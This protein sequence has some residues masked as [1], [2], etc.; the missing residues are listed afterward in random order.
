M[1]KSILPSLGI[2]L[3][4][5]ASTALAKESGNDNETAGLT[6]GVSVPITFMETSIAHTTKDNNGDNDL[7]T[8]VVVGGSE[9]PTITSRTDLP[10]FSTTPITTSKEEDK[11]EGGETTAPPATLSPS[12]RGNTELSTPSASS[13]SSSPPPS[14]SSS[15]PVSTSAE[16]ATSPSSSSISISSSI[17]SSTPSSSSSSTTTIEKEEEEQTNLA[18]I[19]TT[20]TPVPSVISE[21]EP[22]STGPSTCAIGQPVVKDGYT[23]YYSPV[24]SGLSSPA[25]TTSDSE[26]GAARNAASGFIALFLSLS[27]LLGYV[28]AVGP[29]PAQAEAAHVHRP[30]YY[31]HIYESTRQDAANDHADS[32]PNK[33]HG[34]TIF[35]HSDRPLHLNS[36]EDNPILSTH[37]VPREDPSSPPSP[38]EDWALSH[39]LDSQY[40]NDGV[41]KAGLVAKKC[42]DSCDRDD[43]CVAFA[44]YFASGPD[45]S[46]CEKYRA[47]IPEDV[48]RDATVGTMGFNKLCRL[49]GQ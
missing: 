29:A 40:Y 46:I 34:S 22:T 7:A 9:E 26:S 23:I 48:M 11:E 5:I 32:R 18:P 2:W 43:I 10:L 20:T 19:N 25:T 31:S 3:L 12:T 30:R 44:I 35:G 41:R 45:R 21:P 47:L 49:E 28:G 17:S 4:L 36:P 38:W 15:T 6:I 13:S 24:G 14:S 1:K 42:Q 16:P 39:L 33:D 37:L 8:I 27:N